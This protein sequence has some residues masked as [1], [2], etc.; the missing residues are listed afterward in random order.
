L[1]TTV[2]ESGGI[3]APPQVELAT[4]TNSG[5]SWS[6]L[7]PIYS[8]SSWAGSTVELLVVDASPTSPHAGAIYALTQWGSNA[9]TFGFTLLTSTD[10]GQTWQAYPVAQ[11]SSAYDHVNFGSLAVAADGTLYAA[12]YRCQQVGYFCNQTPQEQLSVSRDGG[13]SWSPP[14][15]IPPV[16]SFPTGPA[17]L[18]DFYGYIP[19]SDCAFTA[20]GPQIA[21][22]RSGGPYTG[23]LYAVFQDW[24]GS[25]GVIVSTYSVNGGQ[26]WS[27]PVVVESDY[28]GHDH[29]TPSVAVNSQGAELVSWLDR[30]ND[31][32]N[33]QYEAYGA[34]SLDGGITFPNK[35][36]ATAPSTPIITWPGYTAG[37]VFIATTPSYT[38]VTWIDTRTGKTETE[39]GIVPLR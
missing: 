33:V 6:T 14:M 29:F 21:V 26:S 37:G 15:Q 17:C 13:Q 11:T 23:R 19:N 27:R 2:C 31:P 36:L 8:N 34:Q 4:S 10:H 24:T 39:V 9:Y 12:W 7:Q 32:Q 28:S 22:D 1:T 20:A 18:N 5:Q 16:V 38:Y 3:C 35:A 25:Y 30:R